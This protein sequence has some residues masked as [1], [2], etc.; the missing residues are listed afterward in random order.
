MKISEVKKK[1]RNRWVLAEV[2]K[3]DGLNRAIDV[4]P[5]V[6]NTDR[7]KIYDKI[8]TL[9]KGTHVTTFYTG[10]ISGTFILNVTIKV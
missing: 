6:T 2:L 8:A 5:I 9:P 1:Y 7:D 3:E 10:K 4:K